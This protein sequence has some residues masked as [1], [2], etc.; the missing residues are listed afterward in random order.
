VFVGGAARVNGLDADGPNLFFDF[1]DDSQTAEAK[2]VVVFE[3]AFQLFDVG[4][5]TWIL[6]DEINGRGSA[7]SFR[8]AR[9]FS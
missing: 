2:A 1:I 9:A 8:G 4:M 6:C 3:F 7:R 5:G